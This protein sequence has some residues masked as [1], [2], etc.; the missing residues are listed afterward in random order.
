M[1]N[2]KIEDQIDQLSKDE[3]SKVDFCHFKQVKDMCGN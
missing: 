1:F 2:L 3:V